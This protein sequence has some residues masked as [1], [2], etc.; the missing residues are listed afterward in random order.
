MEDYIGLP[1]TDRHTEGLCHALSQ[2]MICALQQDLQ[3]ALCLKMTHSKQMRLLQPQSLQDTDS[4][5]LH[6]YCRRLCGLR[7]PGS[8]QLPFADFRLA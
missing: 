8:M 6:S 4:V 1:M 7:L 3:N 2:W 5:S